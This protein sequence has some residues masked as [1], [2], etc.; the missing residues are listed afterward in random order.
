MMTDIVK[1]ASENKHMIVTPEH[2]FKRI[3][4]EKRIE[5]ILTH[6]GADVNII[7][8][9]IDEY[10]DKIQK[11]ENEH[12][13]CLSIGFERVMENVVQHS[14]SSDRKA[15]TIDMLLIA[16]YDENGYC[17]KLMKYFNIEKIDLLNFISHGISKIG[18][19]A[20]PI[21]GAET[22]LS[23]YTVELV[24]LAKQN[25]LD[26]VIGRNEE[27]QKMLETLNR[28]TKNNPIIIGDPGVGKTAIIE[29]L[30]QLISDNKVPK[31][32][33]DCK[34]YQLDIGSLLAGTKFRGEFEERLKGLLFELT[35]SDKNILYIDEIHNIVGAGASSNGTMDASNILKPYLVKGQIKFIGATTHEECKKFF[36]KD[37]ALSR[38]F[39]KILVDEPSVNDTIEIMNGLKTKYEEFHKV[40]YTN[41]SIIAAVNLSN[42]YI[43]NRKLPDKAIDV[44][45]QTA[46]RL[47]LN[48]DIDAP[49][50]IGIDD[51]QLTV[52]KMAGVPVENVSVNEIEKLKTMESDLKLNI[53]E[54]NEAVNK[55]VKAIKQYRAGLRNPLKPIANLLFVGPTGVGKTELVKQL[56]NIMGI[57]LVR[58]DMSEYQEKHTVSKLIG[59]PPG[60]VG[61]ENGGLLS[62][63]IKKTPHCIL[64]LDEIEK[65]NEDIYNILLQI[66]DYGTFTDN[67]GEKINCRNIML[68]M[69]S[70]CGAT[71]INK[72]SIGFDKIKNA[73]SLEAL[74][75]TFKP[76][77]RGRLDDIIYFNDLNDVMINSIIERE[78]KQLKE[79]LLEKNITFSITQKCKEHIFNECKNSNGGARQVITIIDKDLKPQ[80]TDIILFSTNGNYI[81]DIKNDNITVEKDLKE[82]I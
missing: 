53:F 14:Y 48:N 55:V 7:K 22:F 10:L 6:C 67:N 28:R 79:K 38:R 43:N 5:D 54:Q 23:K 66:M 18:N 68:I 3:L 75:T 16:L 69:T 61:Y 74:E 13:Q 15:I 44:I 81:V 63:Q 37:R 51:I 64:L 24:E 60:Y 57:P 65:A 26:P 59:A 17:C 70:N 11:I 8:Q 21:E 39:Q 56:S 76:E 42:K 29:G 41:D 80:F 31:K 47:R 25:K 77:F 78:I 52:S 50:A 36:D 27:M 40:N 12:K 20:K 32:L 62:E 49:I 9:K 73:K 30:A 35:Q 4:Q 19:N 1:Y 71:M 72:T 46:S 2:M 82:V 58:F 33:N 34:V 45:D